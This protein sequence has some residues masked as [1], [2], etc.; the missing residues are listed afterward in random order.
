MYLHAVVG[1]GYWRLLSAQPVIFDFGIAN[2]SSFGYFG[3]PD[4]GIAQGSVFVVFGTDSA[5]HC[6]SRPVRFHSHGANRHLSGCAH[7]QRSVLI[8]GTLSQ[9]RSQRQLK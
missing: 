3:R 4:Q 6:L 2:A 8:V 5:H 9:G 7:I 1:A